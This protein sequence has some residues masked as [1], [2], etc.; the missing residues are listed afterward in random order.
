MTLT[1]MEQKTLTCLKEHLA[2]YDNDFSDITAEVLSADTKIPMKQ[3]RGVLASLVKKD[4]IFAE[5]IDINGK[6]ETFFWLT[7]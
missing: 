5:D 1:E 3:I 6:P 2:D 7:D 4:L